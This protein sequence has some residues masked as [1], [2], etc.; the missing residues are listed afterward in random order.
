M[1]IESHEISQINFEFWL[2]HLFLCIYLFL[3]GGAS[4]SPVEAA[5]V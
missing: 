3:G 4:V 2:R 1:Q 5:G